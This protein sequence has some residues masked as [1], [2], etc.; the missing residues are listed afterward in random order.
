MLTPT[1]PGYWLNRSESFTITNGTLSRILVDVSPAQ[2]VS[3]ISGETAL[4]YGNTVEPSVRQRVLTGGCR[5][6]D[7][8]I[9]STDATA[10][11]MNLYMGEL[12]TSLS[13][14]TN[15]V[16]GTNAINRA[17]GSFITDSWVI[18]E[19]LMMFNTATNAN[20]GLLVQ[21]TGVTATTIT[22][23]GTALTNDAGLSASTRLFR[24][25]L[26]GNRAIAASS[27]SNGTTANVALFGGALDSSS[28][29]IQT[30]VGVYLG[31]TGAL[32]VGMAAAISALPARVDVTAHVGL[33]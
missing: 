5:I 3:V 26:R 19:S 13:S 6:V 20:N 2:V 7:G 25:A 21:I 30:D 32:I 14:G 22:V 31:A 10:R 23:N 27:G 12:V 4:P 33:Y 24:V 28:A 15:T 18:G 1:Y 11:N 17:S 8:A 9:C 16:T 29:P